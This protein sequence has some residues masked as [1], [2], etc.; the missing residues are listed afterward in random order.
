MTDEEVRHVPEIP[1][2][3]A[4][5]QFLLPVLTAPRKIPENRNR[6]RTAVRIIN[7]TRSR[8]KIL[9]RSPESAAERV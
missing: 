1:E 6:N 4:A 2:R 8:K 3:A 7:M 5:L 9:E